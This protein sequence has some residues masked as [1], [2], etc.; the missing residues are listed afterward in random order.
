ME[1]GLLNWR[2]LSNCFP[3]NYT[4]EM[5][6]TSN[7]RKFQLI[8]ILA[9]TLCFQLLLI[10]PIGGIVESYWCFSLNILHDVEFINF[11]M[12]IWHVYIL[13]DEVSIFNLRFF[14]Y[15][16]V[17]RILFYILDINLPPPFFFQK[18]VLWVFPEFLEFLFILLISEYYI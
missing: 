1:V 4:I 11:F 8:H 9:G 7:I 13:F 14:F 18:S 17:L 16:W 3:K 6:F 10:F 15:C 2:W 12:F 5:N